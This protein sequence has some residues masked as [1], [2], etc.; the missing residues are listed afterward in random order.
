MSKLA[1]IFACT[2]VVGALM[3]VQLWYQLHVERNGGRQLQ[4]TATQKA[5]EQAP[6]GEQ[7]PDSRP[8]KTIVL[9]AVAVDSDMPNLTPP[10]SPAV[11]TNEPGPTT[12]DIGKLL[13]DPRFREAQQA[14]ARL[15]MPQ[16]YPGVARELG[17]TPEEAEEFF[18]MLAKQQFE[19]MALTT[20][21]QDGDAEAGLKINKARKDGEAAMAR[22]LGPDREQAWNDYQQ[23][24]GARRQISQL[25]T[26][27]SAA[28]RPLTDSQAR[29]LT[30]L[31]AAEQRRLKDE[32]GFRVKPQD[33]GAQT[34]YNEAVLKASEESNIRIIEFA[35]TYLSA[36]QLDALKTS[37]AQRDNLTRIIVNGRR[38]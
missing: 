16:A 13:R 8:K 3:V 7:V 22:F 18:D 36:Q 37:L 10:A 34:Q 35:K 15:Q 19:R 33:P 5:F 9:G 6:P 25:G 29:Q 30:A 23:S 12:I 26:L 28:G 2:T 21:S 24:L 14:Q 1:A 27:L 31:V 4:T 20:A 17:L 32:I 11:V 38:E